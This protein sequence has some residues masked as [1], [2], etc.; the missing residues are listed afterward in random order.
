MSKRSKFII[1]L[2]LALTAAVIIYALF[3]MEHNVDTVPVELPPP[4]RR[5]APLALAAAN[6]TSSASRRTPSRP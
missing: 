3:G 5:T 2:L 1:I 6:R 4:S